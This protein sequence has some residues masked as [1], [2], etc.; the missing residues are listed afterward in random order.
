MY[1]R[2]LQTL[3]Y[4]QGASKLM[5]PAH[6][7]RGKAVEIGATN[8]LLHPGLPVKLPTGREVPVLVA[9]FEECWRIVDCQSCIAF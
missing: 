5:L 4:G 3:N 9:K 2:T 6:Q 1:L 7:C 8:P